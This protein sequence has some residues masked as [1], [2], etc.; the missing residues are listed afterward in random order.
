[1]DLIPHE[2]PELQLSVYQ[3]KVA[4]KT[5]R[6]IVTEINSP[7]VR[8]MSNVY[9]IIKRAGHGYPYVPRSTMPQTYLCPTDEQALADEIN[10]SYSLYSPYSISDVLDAAYR[11]KTERSLCAHRFF[12]LFDLVS[13]IS[14]EPISPPSR[15][16]VANFGEKYSLD[17]KTSRNLTIERLLGCKPEII[18]N[19]FAQYGDMI[20]N[21]PPELIFGAD[22]TMIDGVK[23]Q[24]VLV[25]KSSHQIFA[26]VSV[27]YPHMTA[28]L[29]HTAPG[30]SAPPF[31]IIPSLKKKTAE[32]L[33]INSSLKCFICSNEKAWMTTQAF[34]LWSIYFTHFVSQYRALFPP[35]F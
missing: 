12:L 15:Q 35:E 4:G 33:K 29:A 3:L 18:Q 19:F 13:L 8:Y 31:I 34:L 16:W 22:E 28:M 24:K 21:T 1:M 10:I 11:I 6:E 27:C 20:K 26:S 32:I 2:L 25:P 5:M 14:A 17:I 7:D 23:S 9:C 30:V